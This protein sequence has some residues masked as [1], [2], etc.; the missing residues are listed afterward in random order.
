M[1]TNFLPIQK[2]HWQN[3]E[4]YNGGTPVDVLSLFSNGFSTIKPLGWPPLFSS[5]PSCLR[6]MMDIRRALSL[7][8]LEGHFMVM[9]PLLPKKLIQWE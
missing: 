6:G 9:T 5:N 4:A 3:I 1:L 2:F 8:L 7:K